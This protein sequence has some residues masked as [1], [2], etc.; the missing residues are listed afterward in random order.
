MSTPQQ[1]YNSLP[2]VAKMFAV[3]CVMVSGAQYLGLLSYWTISLSYSDVFLRFQVW[4]LITNFFFL[5]PYSL[6]F[7]FHLLIILRNGVQLERGPYDKRTA[8]YV[9]MFIFGAFSLLL[10]AA[11]PF[12]QTPFLGGSLVFMIVYIW[13]REFANARVNIHGIVELKGFYLPWYVLLIDL[14]VGNPLMPDLMGMAAGHL[15]YFL[16]VIYPLA[17][18]SNFFSTPYWVYPFSYFFIYLA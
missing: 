13:G 2:P 14:L 4:R 10:M 11:I 15:Y 3:T 7:A 1:Y 8:D 18:G 17:G 12:L 6:G 5:G 9:W 16:T